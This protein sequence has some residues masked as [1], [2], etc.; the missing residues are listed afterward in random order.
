MVLGKHDIFS[1]KNTPKGW[2]INQK[3]PSRCGVCSQGEW[4]CPGLQLCWVSS[5]PG[6]SPDASGAPGYFAHSIPETVLCPES[7]PS[8]KKQFGS[9]WKQQQQQ[10]RELLGRWM[11]QKLML[12]RCSGFTESTSGAAL[13]TLQTRGDRENDLVSSQS[14]LG[15]AG[16]VED[17]ADAG[18]S[19]T[20][21]RSAS[22]Q[23]VL[24]K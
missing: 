23:P 11:L 12:R 17:A 13:Q 20:G 4:K 21:T 6:T 7:I 5:R 22:A 19:S 15:G 2:K 14:S 10:Q 16:R 24:G 3:A 8:L 18:L 9:G 1:S